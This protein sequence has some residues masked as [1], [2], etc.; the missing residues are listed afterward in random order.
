MTEPDVALTDYLLA[1]ESFLFAAILLRRCRGTRSLQ[2]WFTI[3]FAAAGVASACGG[4]VHGF[5]HEEQTT[6]YAILWRATLLAVGV[7]TLANWATAAGLLFSQRA[8][9]WVIIA[10]GV[11]FV[12]YCVA[13]IFLT[14]DFR[15][16]IADNLPAV[17][18]LIVALLLTYRRQSRTGLLVA[19][20]GLSLTLLA[21][22][23]QQFQIAI[24]P[25]CFN[26][27]AVFHVIQAT[28]ILLLFL[29]CRS[30][31]AAN[32]GDR[33]AARAELRF[34]PLLPAGIDPTKACQGDSHAH[35]P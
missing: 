12:A 18:F 20:G 32:A 25:H 15:I 29:G 14:Q 4:T 24:H 21:A 1:L 7:A 30:L 2:S 10:A 26:H 8:T 23:L 19:A 16:A 6:G 5:F 22:R 13:V 28:A 31:I 33:S 35:A 27:N 17:L 9:R 11:Q 3:F 34:S